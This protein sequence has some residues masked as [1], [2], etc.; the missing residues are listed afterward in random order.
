MHPDFLDDLQALRTAFGAAMPVTSGYRCPEHNAKI[1]K[2]GPTGPHTTGRA[3]DIGLGGAS[4]LVLVKLALE[5]GFTGLG[6]NQKG[7]GRFIHL[8]KIIDGPRPNIWSY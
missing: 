3:V 5:H 1:S 8:D 7:V 2:T 4:A 6:V